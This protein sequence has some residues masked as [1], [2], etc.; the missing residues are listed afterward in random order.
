MPFAFAEPTELLKEPK[1]S[2][3]FVAD[4][5]PFESVVA[6]EKLGESDD[7]LWFQVRVKFEGGKRNGW[8]R[9]ECLK[10]I[11][12]A[13]L[14]PI[15]PWVF[16]KNCTLA[17]RYI[18]ALHVKQADANPAYGANRDYLLAWAWVATKHPEGETD[19]LPWT[20]NLAKEEW[21]AFVADTHFNEAG[22]DGEDF[23]DPAADPT[24]RI[25]QCYGAAY[26][27]YR[28]QMAISQ[29]VSPVLVNDPA[30]NIYVPNS[31][32][33]LLAHV[34]GPKVA[35]ALAGIDRNI[36]VADAMAQHGLSA[37]TIARIKTFL[38]LPDDAATT[39]AE[40]V[41][42]LEIRLDDAF[43]KTRELL[44][45]HTPED[46][47]TVPASSKA[48]W[49]AVARAEEAKKVAE[50]AD[51]RN[52]EILKYFDATGF[53]TD[54]VA[55]W[56]GAFVAWCMANCGNPTVAA[57]V[58]KA[59][60]ARAASWRTWG[61]VDLPQRADDLPEGAL[62]LLSPID[63]KRNS[64]HVGF[65]VRRGAGTMTLLGGNQSNRV[66]ETPYAESRIV[67]VRWL[68]FSG[69]ETVV[70]DKPVET[71]EP[72]EPAEPGAAVLGPFTAADWERYRVR[73][74]QRE[75]GNVY[76]IV[77]PF[78][79]CGRW[80]M[81]SMALQDLGYV[82]A[83]TGQSRKIMARAG[84]WTGKNGVGSQSAFLTSE[85]IQDAV[86]LAYTA[87]NY[88]R[89]LRLGAL[90]K[91]AKKH[92]VAG[93]LAAAHLVGPGGARDLVR[94]KGNRRDGNGVAASQYFA[95]LA[96]AFG[97]PRKV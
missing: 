74:G 34:A 25:A 43:Q 5:G 7:K 80:Q 76:N 56:C 21:D 22:Y 67:A 55:D 59:M 30:N 15:R 54:T 79:Y 19:E 62:V 39:I 29:E 9:A 24:F 61:N 84:S 73:L 51:G 16:L 20:F 82:R 8:V 75:S 44:V 85:S 33:L 6:V 65:F 26:T 77:N 1:A 89:L 58:D 23:A 2:G 93:V 69:D 72:I 91:E 81:G 60:A 68:N 66:Q 28:H 17:A 36:K 52:P 50:T 90:D 40:A 41:Q 86:M 11:E 96:E 46:V 45:K 78:G 4:V 35:A 47:A 95:M 3:D 48:P 13:D 94:G 53:K 64:G 87:L 31:I 83:G 27:A 92:R 37:E 10:E 57:S 14:L 71:A 42:M 97:G 38:K 18:N 12:P 70:E 63:P 49:M 32:E 88:K